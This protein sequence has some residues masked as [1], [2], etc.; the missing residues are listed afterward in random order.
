MTCRQIHTQEFSVESTVLNL[1]FTQLSTE[2]GEWF[3]TTTC[4]LF[5]DGTGGHIR[6][7]AC[8]SDWTVRAEWTGMRS[9]PPKYHL[10][11]QM[12]S[13]GPEVPCPQGVETL[14]MRIS[15]RMACAK[16]PAN[17]KM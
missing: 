13:I 15:N 12:C 7:I 14:V 11:R 8:Q 17:R 4:V 3:P 1:L 9:W 10:G 16:I 5:Q 6:C 2:K